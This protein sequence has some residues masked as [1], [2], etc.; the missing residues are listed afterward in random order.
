MYCYLVYLLTV[1]GIG[2]F[3]TQSDL[4]KPIRERVTTI[5]VINKKFAP[6]NWLWDKFDGVI[7]CIYCASF[8][9]GLATYFVMYESFN[10]WT[11]FYAFSAMGSIYV[12]KNIFNKN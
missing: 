6:V 3:V 11:I 2:Y 4:I 8:W 9:I 12:I 10:R 5:N 7:N 1:I